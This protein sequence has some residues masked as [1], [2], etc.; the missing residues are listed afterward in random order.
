MHLNF[1]YLS[2]SRNTRGSLRFGACKFARSATLQ[3]GQ[4]MT[5]EEK[6]WRDD[7][8]RDLHALEMKRQN[9]RQGKTTS[10]ECRLR[11]E[12]HYLAGV[13]LQIPIDDVLLRRCQK[14]RT[15]GFG[16]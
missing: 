4:S 11:F 3:R 10:M 14:E 1:S 8:G 12:V 2:P 13:R 5:K 16:L 7:V 15:G 9:R 6:Q